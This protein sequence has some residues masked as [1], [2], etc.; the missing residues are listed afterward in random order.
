MFENDTQ[1]FMSLQYH[2]C[3]ETGKYRRTYQVS[4]IGLSRYFELKTSRIWRKA[5]YTV[6]AFYLNLSIKTHETNRM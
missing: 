1:G 6:I 5:N 3:K 2:I 4:A